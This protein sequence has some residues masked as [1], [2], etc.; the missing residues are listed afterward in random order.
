MQYK[1]LHDISNVEKKFEV[2]QAF[3]LIPWEKVF[4]SECVQVSP[5]PLCTLTQG[6]GKVQRYES[7]PYD[8][9]TLPKSPNK[10]FVQGVNTK[11]FID[12]STVILIISLLTQ[13]PLIQQSN[14]GGKRDTAHKKNN[15]LLLLF[16][17]F[18]ITWILPKRHV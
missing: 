9:S 14:G 2:R 13:K 17:I 7:E 10:T 6:R 16:L 3:F 5:S 11:I 4:L 15:G 1:L 18:Q 8:S 12:T